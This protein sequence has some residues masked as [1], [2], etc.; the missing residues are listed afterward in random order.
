MGKI[1]AYGLPLP[2]YYVFDFNIIENN[3]ASSV[4][5]DLDS[6]EQICYIQLVHDFVKLANLTFFTIFTFLVKVF[7]FG[8]VC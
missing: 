3:I 6:N 2:I 5:N 1:G 4:T 8:R 7:L